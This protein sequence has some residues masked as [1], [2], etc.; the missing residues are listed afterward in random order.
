MGTVNTS[1]MILIWK[2][3]EKYIISCVFENCSS[4]LNGSPY[5]D[6]WAWFFISKSEN[7]AWLE[8]LYSCF[9]DMKND[10]EDP[11]RYNWRCS[12]RHDF[13]TW[14]MLSMSYK[15][16]Q[17]WSL[18]APKDAQP[19]KPEGPVPKKG[20]RALLCFELGPRLDL[21]NIHNLNRSLV[22]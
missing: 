11:W 3:L 15:H 2:M 16:E 7:E 19:P 18:W 9:E 13:F 10:F 5:M 17:F 1:L 14:L 20:L 22:G 6:N 4:F 21:E 12:N 8:S